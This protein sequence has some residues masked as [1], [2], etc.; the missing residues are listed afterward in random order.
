MRKEWL[1][2]DYY[3]LLGVPKDASQRD[4]K[5]AY[6]KLAQQHHPDAN[7]D[8]GGAEAKFKDANEAYDVLGDAEQRKEYDHAR[9]MGYFVG[10]PGG[11]QQYVRVEDLFGGGGGSQMEDL[12]GGFGDLF[13]GAGRRNRPQPGRDLATSISISFHEGVSGTTR[14]VQVDGK[15]VKFE[16]PKGVADSARVRLRGKGGPGANGAPNGDLYITVHVADHPIFSRRGRD[17]TIDVPLTYMEAALG[18]E[19][20]VPTLNGSVKLRIPTGTPSGK[21][22][23]VK[24][25]GV[26]DAKDR[27]GNLLVTV[28]VAVPQAL[29]DEE[30][31]LLEKL[32][33]Q[34]AGDNPRKHLG[35]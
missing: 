30:R 20:T 1:E 10:G 3:A 13:G 5:K 31:A 16:V 24:G 34:P 26:T 35:V 21:R 33:D 6:R 29:T 7:P 12:L 32:R 15:R 27:T 22:F 17:L 28:E 14:E 18:A 2:K 9:E 4:I 23:K 25:R 19:I 8:N 11:N